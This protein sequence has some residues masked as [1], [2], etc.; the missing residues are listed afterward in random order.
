[1]TVRGQIDPGEEHFR[2]AQRLAAGL[3]EYGGAPAMP[4][5]AYF[6]SWREECAMADRIV[7][8]SEWARQAMVRA[9]IPAEKLRIIPLGYDSEALGLVTDAEL[10]LRSLVR[11]LKL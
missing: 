11:E 3:P 2:I 8:N 9:R 4:P 10:F 5:A 7:V 6:A 1:M